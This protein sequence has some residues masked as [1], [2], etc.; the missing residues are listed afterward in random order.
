VTEMQ[1][2]SRACT[3]YCHPETSRGP[4][5]AIAPH[6]LEC[7]TFATA[8]IENCSPRGSALANSRPRG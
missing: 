7:I 1:V 2:T 5:Q 8:E 6:T 3:V 4:V